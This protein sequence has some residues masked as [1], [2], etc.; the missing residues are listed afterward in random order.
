MSNSSKF[1]RHPIAFCAG[2]LMANLLAVPLASFAQKPVVTQETGPK[3]C[4]S[5]AEEA[6]FFKREEAFL[7]RRH[8]AEHART[9]VTQCEVA[10][11]IHKVPGK[12]KVKPAKETLEEDEAA[13]LTIL[14]QVDAARIN[15]T[16]PPVETTTGRWSSPFNIPVVGISAVL[17]HTG[18]VFF[19]SYDPNTWGDPSQSK[20]GVSYLWDPVNR[21]ASEKITPPENIWCGGQTILSD[22][23]VYIAGGNLRY[24][25]STA[26]IGKQGWAGT[27]TSYTFNPLAK[28]WTSQPNMLH[29]RWYPTTT[30]LADNRVVVTSGYDETG[31][32]A[33]N[34][35]VEVFTPNA[36]MD[37]TGS[38][39]KV[40]E[41]KSS[42]LYPYQFLLPSG[43]ML[44]AGPDQ[45]SS[46][47][48]DPTNN[49]SWTKLPSLVVGHYGYGNAI[50]YTNAAVSP[51]KQLIMVAG[52]ENGTSAVSAN[53]WLDGNNPAAGWRDYPDWKQGRHNSNTVI[54]PDGTLLTVGGN[55][56]PTNYG[57]P[58]FRPELYSKPADDITGSWQFVAEHTVQAAYHSSALLLPDATVLLSQDDYGLD[59]A[60]SASKHMAQVYSPPYLFK[61]AQPVIKTAPTSLRVGESFNV[62][63]DRKGMTSAVLVAPGA[64]THGNDMHQRAIK[65]A[66]K[67]RRNEF[68]L[69][70]TVPDS[71]SVVPPGYYMLFVLDGNGIPS[72]AKFVQIT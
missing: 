23:Q 20:I 64:T 45:A 26:P 2:L 49:W 11:S 17:L 22:G 57:T 67:G 27:V 38:M 15:K 3:A 30:Q 50:S 7:G 28:T 14:R 58:E 66:T 31:S 35:D 8:A 65:L 40:G 62:T 47:L 24:P 34:I 39:L 43:K 53:E 1:K 36:S 10:R 13:K 54:L 48:L 59:S 9:R 63:T 69:T 61:G 51:A 41:H 52:G 56:G 46:H 72:V 6:E 18:K 42:G 70:A 25:D 21:M 5:D 60:D 19:W 55:S 71:S 29:G 16:P 12:D 44:Q 32:E 37:R 68:E 33:L 4:R